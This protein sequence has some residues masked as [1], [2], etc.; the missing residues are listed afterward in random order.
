M[1]CRKSREEPVWRAKLSLPFRPATCGMPIKESSRSGKQAVAYLSLEQRKEQS[2]RY[3]LGHHPNRSSPGTPRSGARCTL[4]DYRSLPLAP[5]SVSPTKSVLQAAGRFTPLKQS[6]NHLS[7]DKKPS[8]VLTPCVLTSCL[9]TL[10]ISGPEF[11]FP[12]C[13][14]RPP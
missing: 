13:T 3:K 1:K 14:V 10:S 12:F 4:L 11:L 7:L 6:S 5:S 9:P 8:V 2:C